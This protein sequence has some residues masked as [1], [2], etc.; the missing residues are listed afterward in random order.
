MVTGA[1]VWGVIWYPYRILR[2][3]GIG[4]VQ[5]TTLTY[6]V[7][8]ILAVL[9]WRPRP[10]RPTH[11]WLM[12]A[13]ALAAGGCNLG[14]VMA[15]IT[16]EVVRVLLLFY[17]APLWTVLLS[18][19]L[20]GE[21]LNR[22]GVFVILLSLAGAATML[23]RPQTGLP[24]PRDVAD[25]MGLGAGFSFALFN[26]LSRRAREVPVEQRVM[27]SFA[28]VI[29]IGLLL[30]GMQLPETAAAPAGAWLL[31][32]L[33]GGVLLAVNLVVQFG[34]AN[35]Q[36]NQAIVIMLS[37]VG[38]A[39]VS[40]WLLAGEMLGPQEWLGGTMIIAASLFTTKMKT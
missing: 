7:A 18:R 13:L 15:T 37:E 17:L 5:A 1:L 23:W 28:G 12:M 29:V 11:P 33:T 4:G 27:V 26:V 10:T 31:L 3:A 8:L 22:F 2:D 30:G 16:G 20:L 21:R 19:F 14:Y 38:F 25:W 40:S 32:L 9:V 36:A 24:L 35:T 39:A 34:L 6:A